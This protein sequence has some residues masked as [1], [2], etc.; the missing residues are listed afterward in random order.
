MQLVYINIKKQ[1]KIYHI[2]HLIN[3]DLIIYTASLK[4]NFACFTHPDYS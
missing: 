4:Y 1:L 2:H 3:P